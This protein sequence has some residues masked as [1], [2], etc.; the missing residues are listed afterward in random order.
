ML[1]PD[2]RCETFCRAVAAGALVRDLKPGPP[3]KHAVTAV[4]RAQEVS[5]LVPCDEQ[6]AVHVEEFLAF[7]YG[8]AAMPGWMAVGV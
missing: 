3:N 1:D 5:Y 2:D 6:L 7:V 8:E 4:V